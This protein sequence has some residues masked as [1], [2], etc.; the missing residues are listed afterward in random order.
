MESIETKS[1]LLKIESKADAGGFSGYAATWWTLDKVGDVLMPGCFKSDLPRFLETNFVGDVN[2]NYNDPIGRFEVGRED[3]KGLYVE[4][5]FSDVPRAKVV[6]TLI[7][8]RVIQQLSIG[9]VPQEGKMITPGELSALWREN[10]YEPTEED[11]R[12]LKLAKRIRLVTKAKLLEVSPTP[13]PVNDEARILNYKSFDGC[14][15][16]AKVF[17][18]RM[19]QSARQIAGAD[20]KAGR[21]L[22]G[23]NEATL[24]SIRDLLNSIDSEINNL[25]LLV[26][27]PE[28]ETG[29][30]L[31][32]DGP[33]EEATESP[34][35][36]AQESPAEEVAEALT[37]AAKLKLLL[38]LMR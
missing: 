26:G 15:P 6:R 21:V 3:G 33:L 28:T 35:E 10:G 5:K 19:L 25:L 24:R 38:G 11:N 32:A 37:E 8:D 9:F 34:A 17:A 18:R 22:S 7:N 23:K 20:L 1:L 12:H 27:S 16:A 13:N 14:P 2:H 30:E 29:E 31:E 4:A 36:E